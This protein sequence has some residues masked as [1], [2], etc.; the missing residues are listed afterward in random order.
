MR[1]R[2]PQMGLRRT[3]YGQ[4][5][6]TGA[7]RAQAAPGG[8]KA[9]RWSPG[10]GGGQG[11][12]HKRSYLS[13]VEKQ[14]RCDEHQPSQIESALRR[15]QGGKRAPAG[16]TD[17]RVRAGEPRY[18]YRRV[19]ALLRRESWPVN[20]KRVHRLWREEGLKVTERQH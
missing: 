14:L 10:P 8:G 11:A 12:G 9:S 7:D 5:T 1:V 20:K 4:T 16:R 19:W 15:P 17:D 6:L 18:G 2:Q 13:S 3:L